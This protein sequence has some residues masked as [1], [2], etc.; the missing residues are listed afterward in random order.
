MKMNDNYYVKEGNM[1]G[2]VKQTNLVTQEI[3]THQMENSVCKIYGKKLNGTGFFCLIQNIK[4]WNPLSL[5]VLITNNHILEEDDIKINKKI[6]MSLNNG[7]KNIEIIIDNS[8]K[9]FTSK[10]YDITIIEIKQN[11]GIKS[12]SFLEIDKDIY[13]DNYKEIYRKKSIYLL[14]YPKGIEICKSEEVIRN[15]SEDNYTIEHYCDSNNGSSGGPLIN[16]ENCKVIGIHKGFNKINLGTILNIPIKK[17]YEKLNKNI[18]L[19]KI[20]KINNTDVIINNNNYLNEITIQYNICDDYRIKLFGGNFVDNNKNKCTI[21]IDKKEYNLCE[22]YKDENL[23]LKKIL[24]IKLKGIKNI[25]NISYM[26]YG[27][28]SLSSLPDISKWNTKNVIYMSSMFSSCNSL[29]SL[30]DISKWDTKNVTD[31]SSMFCCCNKLSSLPDISKWDTKN[32]TNMSYMFYYCN[33]LSSLP[34][35][36]K[37]NTKNVIYMSSMFCGCNKLSSLPDI[38]KWDT[39]NVTN[40]SSMFSYCSSLLSL[41]D[42][43]KWDT[44]NVT[45][46]SYMFSWCKSLSSLPDISKWDTKNLTNMNYM[47][48]DCKENLNIPSKFKYNCFYFLGFLVKYN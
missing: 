22:Y 31:M 23:K 40:M 29:S 33:K 13:K 34:D 45:N 9:T 38:S 18:E 41:P 35:I 16:L 15:I 6:K 43:S 14:H 8:R 4:E 21:I 26:F 48:D 37:W 17:F 2:H 24:E 20:D 7:N 42:I 19:N 25:T 32:V 47:F 27:C 46:M 11:D 10:K 28:H 36:S 12:N 30:P 5:K 3:I 39:K 1:I 44:K